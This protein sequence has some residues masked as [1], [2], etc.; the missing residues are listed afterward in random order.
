MQSDSRELQT[1]HTEM[2]NNC[3]DTERPQSSSQRHTRRLQKHFC[4]SFS[5]GVSSY[6]GGRAAFSMS[7]PRV[8]IVLQ[9]THD[10]SKAPEA[11]RDKDVERGKTSTEES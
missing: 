11:D 10:C 8:P 2:E 9:S 4:V 5:V 6:V 1:N 7:V 3:R